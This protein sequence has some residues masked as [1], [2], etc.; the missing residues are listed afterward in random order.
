MKKG[1]APD[2]SII[3]NSMA[4]HHKFGSF[5]KALIDKSKA[6][7]FARSII[8]DY[9]VRT[10][11]NLNTAVK[12]L[13]GGNMQKLLVGREIAYNP[14]IL[15]A[16]QP[17]AGVDVAARKLIHD[18]F[19]KLSETGSGVIL[20]SGDLEEIMDLAN[21]IIVLYRGRAVAEMSYPDYDTTEIGYYMTGIR[22]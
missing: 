21:R 15:V 1:L 12:A 7:S 19:R 2:R 9:D 11:K 20:I 6:R 13:S 17:T 18:S 8:T 3:E 10:G 5:G 16:S 4:G 14:A 22:G